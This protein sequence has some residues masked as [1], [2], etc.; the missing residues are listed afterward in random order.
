MLLYRLSFL[1]GNTNLT[2]EG[3]F[4]TTFCSNYKHFLNFMCYAHK[5]NANE[6]TKI[7]LK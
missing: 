6:V 1:K 5:T 4:S 2:K 3:S 7:W